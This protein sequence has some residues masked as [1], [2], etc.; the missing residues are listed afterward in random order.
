MDEPN[1]TIEWNT[2][3]TCP[4]CGHTATETMPRT[5]ALVSIPVKV[6]VRFCVPSLGT[7]ACFAPTGLCPAHLFRRMGRAAL[8]SW[9]PYVR[10]WHLA[11][12]L[13]TPPYVRFTPE[14]GHSE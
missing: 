10:F 5:L 2:T 8:N 3:I 9:H 13:C 7:A 12:I 1:A 4:H 14:S 6:A 11:D